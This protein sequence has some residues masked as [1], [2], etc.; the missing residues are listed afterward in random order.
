[1]GTPAPSISTLHDPTLDELSGR[2]RNALLRSGIRSMQDLASLSEQDLLQIKGIG[3]DLVSEILQLV[4]QHNGPS[5]RV[6][7]PVEGAD[8]STGQPS[9]ANRPESSSP[10]PDAHEGNAATPAVSLHHPAIPPRYDGTLDELSARPRNALRRAGIRS[11]YELEQW[12]EDELLCLKNMGRKSVDEVL[13]LLARYPSAPPNAQIQHGVQWTSV[14]YNAYAASLSEAN[15]MLVES[16]PDL[17]R[18]VR[19]AL[20]AAGIRTAA[21]LIVLSTES[22]SKLSSIGVISLDELEL[23]RNRLAK[24]FSLGAIEGTATLKAAQSLQVRLESKERRRFAGNCIAMLRCEIEQG[25]ICSDVIAIPVTT[26][27][28]APLTFQQLI[29]ALAVDGL[30]TSP[31]WYAISHRIEQ[32]LQR[33]E[34]KSVDEELAALIARLTDRELSIIRYR[35]DLFSPLTLEQTG[36]QYGVTRERIRQIQAKAEKKL[37]RAFASASFP[38]LRSAVRFALAVGEYLGLAD[39]EEDLRDRGLIQSEAAFADFLVIWRASRVEAEFPQ[40]WVEAAQEGLTP[41]QLGMRRAIARRALKLCRNSGAVHVSWLTTDASPHDIRQLLVSLGYVEIASEWYWRPS[42]SRDVVANVARKV[43]SVAER[44]TP[45]EFRYALLR[46]LF[47]SGHP[48]APTS[49]LQAVLSRLPFLVW[50]GRV[51][52]R[53]A[54]LSPDAELSGSEL[55]LYDFICAN[56]P[57][58]TF[59]ELFDANRTAGYSAPSLTRALRQSPIL[60]KVRYGLYA[61]IGT[62]FTQADI[63]VA[64]ERVQEIAAGG[65]LR[66]G[67][68]GTVSYVF[69]AAAWLIYSGVVNTTKLRDLAGEWLTPKGERVVV[70][71]ANV[72]GL[73]GLADG[74]GVMPGYRLTL[75]FNTWDQTVTLHRMDRDD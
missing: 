47:R 70:G 66:Y 37:A 38:R 72:Y 53:T 20:S 26:G 60:R 33:L 27:V 18:R 49:V 73:K 75:R 48:A 25:H 41:A 71:R 4:A 44:I 54:E 3:P 62:S 61:L 65:E 10:S 64:T 17:T 51:L 16:V 35:F 68:D 50:D 30:I 13:A 11:I 2:S 5:T 40:T 36:Q 63:D 56:G 42:P 59:Q 67:Q 45:R 32:L 34:Q 23:V 21:A 14:D 8:V 15:Q 9:P 43:F 6:E 57:V 29:D 12:S 19:H 22:L 52:A 69:T 24:S 31:K 55:V 7:R 46:H 39:V 28:S 1:M 74:L 58:V